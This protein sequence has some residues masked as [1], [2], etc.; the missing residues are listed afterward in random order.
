VARTSQSIGT[1]AGQ[2]DALKTLSGSNSKSSATFRN[3]PQGMGHGSTGEPLEEHS[4]T[5]GSEARDRR[6]GTGEFEKLHA[7]LSASGNTWAALAFELAIETSPQQGAL[8][9]VRWE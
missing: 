8:F 5:V 4:Q 2:P 3:R 9:S 1:N 7:L 6:L